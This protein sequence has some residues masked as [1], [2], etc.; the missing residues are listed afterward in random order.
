V[1][2]IF[3]SPH[4]QQQ[5]FSATRCSGFESRAAIKRHGQNF[6]AEGEMT[7]R[8]VL[9]LLGCMILVLA[10]TAAY[11]QAVFGNIVGTAT[12]PQGAAVAG[13]KVTVTSTTKGT[14]VTTTTNDSGN[15][16]VSHLIPDVYK[17]KFESSGF[18]VFE[19]GDVPVSA[20]GTQRVDC[21]FTVGSASETMEV[22]GEAP[23]LQTDKSDVAIEYN[24]TYVQDMPTLN[25]NFT[26]FEL[27]SPGTQKLTGWSHAATENPQG[28][29][30]IFVNG[31]H[32]SGTNFQLD[33]T[34][35]QDPILG[36]I[37]IN[38]N[39]DAVT[40]AK[41]A[42]QQYDAEMGKAI[43][44]YVTAQTKSG[45]NEFH[46]TGFW[47]RRT[48]AN[49]ARDPFTQYQL[50]NGRYIPSSKWQE[51]G[52][53]IGG[54]IIKNKLFFFGDYQG[55]K[56]TTGVTNQYSIPTALVESTCSQTTGFC[57]L[58]QYLGQTG[59]GGGGGVQQG[60][61]FDPT[62]GTLSGSGRTAFAGNLIPNSL[63]S[64]QS[65][66]LLALFPTPNT[67]GNSGGTTNNYVA[68]GSGPY[69]QNAWDGRIDWVATPTLNVFGRYSQQWYSLSG[70]PGLGQA[71]GNGFGPGPGLAGSSNIHNYSVSVGA[72]KTLSQTW[73][74]DFR[75][76]WM[77][78]NP[79]TSKYFQ[80]TTPMSNLGIPGLNITNQGAA[81]ALFTSGYPS[82]FGDGTLSPWGEGLNV[83]RCNCPL[84]EDENQYQGVVNMTKI[85]GNHSFKFGA[86]IRSAS[87]LR[88]PSDANRTGVINFSHLNT[89]DAG[90]G[91]LDLGTF[92]LGDVSQFQR[93]VSTSLNAAE[94]QWRYFFYGQ[95]TWR[96]T[97]KLT[98]N[99][100]LRW[101]LY[102]PETVNG[103]GNGG[104][105][106]A[107][108]APGVGNGVIRVA[109]YGPYGLNGNINSNYHAFAPRFG[110]AYSMNEKTVVRMGFGV[111]YDMG[112]FGSN[113]GH[114]VT[115]NLPVLA[116]QTISAS[117]VIPG[118]SD[119]YITA[120][121]LAQGPTPFVSPVVP[122]SGIL[123]LG[124]PAGNVQPRIRPT[125]QVLPAVAT[126][127]VAIQR[128]LT[129]NLTLDIAYIGVEGRH[130][131]VGDGSAYNLNPVNIQNWALTQAGIISQ[132]QRQYYNNMFS[133][134]YTDANG[135]TTNVLC[136][137]GGVMGNYF[138]N[139]ANSNYNSLQVK[140]QQNMAY[141]LQFIA[142]YTW[143]RALNYTGA[144]TSYFAINP[145][146]DYGPDD[147]N[148]PQ[149]FVANIVYQ[150][151]FGKGKQFG[152]N[153]GRAENLII[154]GW[155]ITETTNWSAGLPFTPTYNE[156]NSDQ[157][158]GVCNPNKGNL[159]GWSMGGGSLNPINHT[160]T[161][162][163]PIQAMTQNCTG[164]GAWARPCAGTLGNAGVDF[165]YGPRSFTTDASIMKNFSL[166][167]RFALQFR[168]D[169]FNLFNHRVLN[170]NSNAGN[171]CVDCMSST[172]QLLNN[173]GL[174]TDIDPNVNMRAL[175][176]ALR[177]SF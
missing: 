71:G 127:N 101:E 143:S 138:G 122:S 111:S 11:G 61:V 91:G 25:R 165:L 142:H 166:T 32:F 133:T 8:W 51:Y 164:Y 17:I 78:Y 153:A 30:Q 65:R 150:L 58:S 31:Q 23:Q 39:L 26:Q 113:F 44:G 59:G 126:W 120:F 156:C 110:M 19:Q 36:I 158:V 155:Q 89:S 139:N 146:V 56:T 130:G 152:G 159:A 129:N 45:S 170:F 86:D 177:L 80:G 9:S 40:E 99:Y 125:S 105:A 79:Q 175:Q 157:D 136:C 134:P 66:A 168:M 112:V 124:G 93:F 141:G 140:M 69:T 116:N 106:N 67:A 22:T 41:V 77:H 72:T 54:P 83:G 3:F 73:L 48:D 117:T 7:K 43:A 52:G 108:L 104:F 68:G 2:D 15:F 24:Q 60:Q 121:N 50:V 162:F 94:H 163:T 160:V 85:W 14:A 98:L 149:V 20:D 29:Q 173:A 38:P 74:A 154:G 75:F 115:Q 144:N 147:Q 102:M 27:M 100:G 88:V 53:S 46:G 174:V 12:D 135:V 63:I 1:S 5:W 151:P 42:L 119:N 16:T 4:Q 148:R 114:A 35:N 172:G 76:G 97:P 70:A 169:A 33:G 87:N 131:F 81:T 37:V 107:S 64:P 49:Q 28:G 123:P 171:T 34:D 167:E 132:S 96:I 6:A 103:K 62:T 145:R 18:K 176:F 47:F 90:I 161:F 128:Q 13:A 137:S 84:I 118:A 21:Q 10:S 55:F 95:D 92:L 82:F 109:G 57:N